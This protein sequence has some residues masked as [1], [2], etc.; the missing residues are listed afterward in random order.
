MKN[1]QSNVSETTSSTQYRSGPDWTSFYT[2]PASVQDAPRGVL[3]DLWRKAYGTPAP[4]GISRRLLEYAAAYNIQVRQS[5][6]LNTVTKRALRKNAHPRPAAKTS[7]P[8]PRKGPAPG[9]RLVREW[10]GKNHTVHVTDNGFFYRDRT[11]G[12]LSEVARVITGAHWSGRR[13]FGL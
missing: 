1:A 13:F 7:K 11:Y 12:S 3:L 6:G 10:H 4:K 2:S 9:T 5:G 8:A